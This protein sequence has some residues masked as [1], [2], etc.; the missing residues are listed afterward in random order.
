LLLIFYFLMVVWSIAVWSETGFSFQS[1][2]IWKSVATILTGTIGIVLFILSILELV[3]YLVFLPVAGGSIR[4]LSQVHGESLLIPLTSSTIFLSLALNILTG[5]VYGWGLWTLLFFTLS[6]IIFLTVNS[7]DSIGKSFE[8][9]DP[10]PKTSLIS[11]LL[12]LIIG[13]EIVTVSAG[14]TPISPWRI[15]KLPDDTWVVD[16]RTKAEFQWN[17]LE[18]A[19]N[20]PWGVGLYDAALS[21]SK[22]QPVLVTCFS[23]HRSPAVAVMLRKM[24]FEQ[25]YN[26]HWGLIYYMILNRGKKQSGPFKLTRSSRDTSG[27]GKDYKAISVAYVSMQVIMLALAPIEKWSTGIHVSGLQRWIGGTIGLSGFV[28]AYMAYRVLGRNF[29]VFAAPRRSGTLATSGIYSKVRHPMYT[30]VIFAFLGYVIYWGSKW[31]FLFWLM[32]TALYV[33]KAY[34][35]ESVLEQR[36]S[37]YNDY[38]KRTWKFIPYIY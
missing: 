18:G 11:Q 29:R 5:S 27:R 17:R 35:E 25:V 3:S 32:M 10:T 31:S 14:A 23:G 26:L 9:N 12:G 7:Q 4:A 33:I 38:R 34:K 15:E 22:S 37:G 20:F 2:G 28:A 1:I 30:A 13:A 19:D 24:G 8:S 16:V 21:H 6:A 36:Y